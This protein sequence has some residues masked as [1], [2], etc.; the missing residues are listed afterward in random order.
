MKFVHFVSV[1]IILLVTSVSFLPFLTFGLPQAGDQSTTDYIDTLVGSDGGY[2]YRSGVQTSI[3][4]HAD[5][6]IGTFSHENYAG[7]RRHYLIKPDGE[8]DYYGY[9]IE[10]GESFPDS[11][12]YSGAGWI[13]DSYFSKLPKAVQKGIM[14]AT[15]FGWQPGQHVPVPGCNDDDWYWATQVIIWEYQ[16]MLRTSTSDIQGNGY[17][18]SNYFQ[19]TLAGRPAEKCYN[20]ILAKMADYE[21]IPSFSSLE[22]ASAP[23]NVLK[24]D[25]STH[26]WVLKI[27]DTNNNSHPVVPEDSTIKMEQNGNVYTFSSTTNLDITA[28]RFKKDVSMPAHEMLIWGGANRTQAIATG[29]ADPINFYAGFRTEQPG[30][31]EIIKTSEDGAKEGFIFELLDSSGQFIN[32]TTDQDGHASI[33][34]Y[35]GEYVL[36]E[37]EN[38]KYRTAQSRTVKIKENETSIIEIENVLKKGQIQIQK[39]VTDSIENV[40]N[41]EIGAIFQIFSADYPSYAN[42]PAHLRDE[43]ETDSQGAAMTKE[44]P[45]GDYIVH[46]VAANK[47]VTT[48]KDI[49]TAITNDLQIMQ[50]AIEN[51][52]QKG[53]IQILKTDQEDHPL[54]GAEFIIRNTEDIFMVD[55]TKKYG[56]GSVIC[57][58]ISNEK[59]L[60][61]SDWLYPGSYEIVEIK[62][63]EGYSPPDN[64]ST[65]VLL[66]TD[67][68][69][70]S[71]IFKQ[72]TIKN[73]VLKDY[74]DTGD[75]NRRLNSRVSIILMLISLFGICV[76]TYKLREQK[77]TRL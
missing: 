26:Q 56:N 20:Y 38:S 68:K 55:G 2:Y 27:T 31:F 48:S 18:S 3:R 43:I 36:S 69:S 65:T 16:Q 58:L 47:S 53:K 60:A 63:P 52:L 66:T 45:L 41:P 25:R 76:L 29:A 59:G 50:L 22:S 7:P 11:Q 46:Q 14:L 28:I 49:H 30:N 51:H 40:S 67:N 70:V 61:I 5:G 64:P 77:K 32:L 17:V 54:A 62:S 37:K 35:P 34:L 6:S 44:L 1:I 21:K 9:C 33:Q 15:I 4:F 23:L 71:T 13:N 10:Q 73:S 8:P 12:R 57:S 75:E 42:T 19:S 24:W 39:K 72:I 74:P